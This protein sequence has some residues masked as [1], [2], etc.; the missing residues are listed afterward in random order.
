MD[1]KQNQTPASEIS[2]GHHCA[3][4]ANPPKSSVSRQES[5]KTIGTSAPRR[6]SYSYNPQQQTVDDTYSVSQS[7]SSRK[8]SRA[9]RGT[10]Q[11]RRSTCTILPSVDGETRPSV[12]EFVHRERISNSTFYT[13]V[14]SPSPAPL[15][16]TRKTS[17]TEDRYYDLNY[18]PL[19]RRRSCAADSCFFSFRGSSTSSFFSQTSSPAFEST[20][21][22]SMDREYEL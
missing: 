11:S 12:S 4:E 15:S 18:S 10:E 14:S 13:A 22:K 20:R 17:S 21:L 1:S 5:Q 19:F 2:N 7:K 8:S 9:S 16:E 3:S 6:V